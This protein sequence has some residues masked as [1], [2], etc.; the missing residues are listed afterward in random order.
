MGNVEK[1][2]TPDRPLEVSLITAI[3][4][5]IDDISDKGMT[6]AEILGCR[7]VVKMDLYLEVRGIE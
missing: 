3:N 4:Q 5:V 6:L 2:D 7:D 1:I